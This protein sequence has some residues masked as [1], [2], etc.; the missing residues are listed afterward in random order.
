MSLW[1]GLL[2]F[3]LA[4][5]LQGG[6]FTHSPVLVCAP[7]CALQVTN[8]LGLPAGTVNASVVQVAQASNHSVTLR[9][10]PWSNASVPAVRGALLAVRPAV[11]TPRR[12]HC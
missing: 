12:M 7:A 10:V 6:P 1:W 5:S 2:L 11:L 8:W 4:W 3:A 9:V